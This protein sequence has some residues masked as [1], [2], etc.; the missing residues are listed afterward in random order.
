LTASGIAQ[1][2]ALSVLKTALQLSATGAES[3][4]STVTLATAI[5]LAAQGSESLTVTMASTQA[6][7]ANATEYSRATAYLGAPVQPRL[8]FKVHR[9]NRVFP[10]TADPESPLSP[11]ERLLQAQ[12]G[13][14]AS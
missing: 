4:A 6:V 7:A 11:L 9:D 2:S 5:L 13:V 1:S 14:K 10:V 3:G 8:P 12:Y